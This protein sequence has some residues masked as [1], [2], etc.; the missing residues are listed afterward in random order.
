MVKRKS[1]RKDFVKSYAELLPRGMFEV[2]TK[3][4]KKHLRGMGIYA[5]YDKNNTLLYVGKASRLSSRLKSHKRKKKEWTKFSFYEFKKKRYVDQIESILLRIGKPPL[6]KQKGKIGFQRSKNKKKL[7]KK[8][9]KQEEK[10]LKKKEERQ[11]K[12]IRKTRKKRSML[13]KLF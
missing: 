12:S 11:K 1:T 13:R 3:P 4:S 2:L 10:R 5:L 7:F 6:N 9:A 8:D